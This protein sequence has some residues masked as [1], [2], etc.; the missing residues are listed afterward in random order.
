MKLEKPIKISRTLLEELKFVKGKMLFVSK[1]GKFVLLE[2]FETKEQNDNLT[3]RKWF[4]KS[5]VKQEH[6]VYLTDIKLWGY[7]TE[8]FFWGV[9]PESSISTFL[10]FYNLMRLRTNYE[11]FV[12]KPL[13][14]LGFEITKIKSD[15]EKEN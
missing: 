14:E 6:N 12:K 8:N 5:F 13:M 4:K 9:F 7:N 2:S 10:Y 11:N 3:I 15:N 1:G